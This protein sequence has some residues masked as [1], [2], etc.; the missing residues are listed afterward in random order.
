MPLICKA[1]ASILLRM[2]AITEIPLVPVSARQVVVGEGIR[3]ALEERGEHGRPGAVFAHG[4]GQTRHA[5]SGT[6]ARVAASGWHTLSYDSRG[7]GD[8][9]RLPSGDYRVEQLVDDMRQVAAAAAAP[10]VIIGASMGGL[11][12]IAMAGS[13]AA[14][15]S[16]LVLVDVTPRWEPAGVARIL[17]FMRAYPDGFADIDEVAEVVARYL[18]HRST[19]KSPERLRGLLTRSAD[20]RLRWHWDPRMLGPIAEDAEHH[21]ADLF[22]AARRIRVPTLLITGA[23]S[24]VVSEQTIS[25]FLELVPHAKH[26][27]VPRATHMVAGD[28]NTAFSRH[29]LEFLETQRC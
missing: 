22:A 24:D 15:C 17:S 2:V 7:H 19:R 23:A 29:V 3:L 8:S 25:E 18:P 28:E 16:A 27:E 21:Q 12:G 14:Y 9:D 10:P 26:V 11:V 1:A 20:G 4:F 6:S 13:D 5:W